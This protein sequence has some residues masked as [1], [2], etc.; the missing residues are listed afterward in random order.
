MQTLAQVGMVQAKAQ[1]Y[2]S[3]QII[4]NL[5][6]LSILIMSFF[7][8]KTLIEKYSLTPEWNQQH[9]LKDKT[10]ADCLVRSTNC[11]SLS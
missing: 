8:V 3:P 4:E 9:L 11:R 5:M 1:Q 10:K 7:L 6:H 2:N